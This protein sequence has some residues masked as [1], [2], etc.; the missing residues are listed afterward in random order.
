MSISAAAKP[1]LV[2]IVGGRHRPDTGERRIAGQRPALS[3]RHARDVEE[4]LRVEPQLLR[5]RE[6][7]AGRDHRGAE[8]HVVADLRSLS[9]A[10]IAGVDHRLAHLGKDRFGARKA[11]VGAADHEGQRARVGGGDATRA[12]ARRPRQG[13]RWRSRLRCS[14]ARSQRRSS[15]NRAIACRRRRVGK[16]SLLD[17][18][19]RHACPR[20]ASSPPLR[21]R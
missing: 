11:F 3:R 21:R 5:E 1:A 20:G 15:S 17:T 2:V 13:Q 8:E 12:P 7:L 14:L 6:R 16:T 10:R 19:Q 4:F 18:E 9:G